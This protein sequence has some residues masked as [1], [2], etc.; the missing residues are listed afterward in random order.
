MGGKAPDA[1]DY[2]AAAEAQG[3]SSREAI[4]DQTYAN[5]PDQTTPWGYTNWTSENVDGTERWTQNTGLRSDLSDIL[6]REIG[7]Q[8][9]R[10]ELASGLTG[11]MRSEFGQPIDYGGLTPMGER[12]YEQF[13]SS[14]DVQRH[15][16]GDPTAMRGRAE[17][18]VYGKAQSRLAPR[19]DSQRQAMEVKLRN[20]GLG[21]EDAAYKAQMSGID[22][23][24]TDAYN[25]AQYSAIDAGK[26]EQQQ[27]WQQIQDQGSFF[28]R[29]GDQAFGQ[30]LAANAQNYQQAMSGS[31]YANQ[32]RQ[33]QIAEAQSLRGQSLNEINALMH[34]QQVSMPN[35]PS[36]TGA[37][38]A[39]PTNY[40]GAAQSQGQSSL[41][42]F[43]AQQGANQGWLSAAGSLY[44]M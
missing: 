40:L 1:P 35:M 25:Q 29:S 21:P 19:F 20:Q 43:N 9:D 12:P 17:D 15:L 22:Q 31:A 28:N 39:Q 23:Q 5:R 7:L 26:G 8:G 44:G 36:F 16:S 37:S 10:T 2:T 13:T 3:A 6:D 33:Q 24:E 4:R 34:G 41:D 11:R 42:A 14:E 18:A 27:A 32:L 38:A 30:N